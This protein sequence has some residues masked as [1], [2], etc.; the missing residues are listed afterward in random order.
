MY[1]NGINKLQRRWTPAFAGVT[2]FVAITLP[3]DL[4]AFLLDLMTYLFDTMAYK[5]SSRRKPGSSVVRTT[6]INA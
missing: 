3:I 4:I 5:L 6:A 2:L 1:T